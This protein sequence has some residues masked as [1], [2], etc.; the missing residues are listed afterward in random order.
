[1]IG[2]VIRAMG[3]T[4]HSPCFKCILCHTE[5]ANIGFVKHKG[6]MPLCKPCNAELK[7]TGKKFCGKCN[8]P[9]HGEHI[10]YRT[11][12]VHPNHYSCKRCGQVLTAKSREKDGELFCLR[13]HD[14][15]ASI[16]ACCHKPIEGRIIHAI[17]KTWHPEHFVC[18]SCEKAFDGRRHYEKKGLAYC[19]TH[20]TELFGEICF[21]CGKACT[22]DDI[23]TVHG[24]HWCRNHFRCVACDSSLATKAGAQYVD[25]DERPYC[26]RCLDRFPQEYR[27]RLKQ[28]KEV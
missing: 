1:M 10:I 8:L 4:W 24:K 26:K 20:Y 21:S 2:R 25:A 23:V 13:C 28:R 19:E 11:E 12:P 9:I 5:L 6:G 22:S 14:R 3:S 16:C 7:E 18:G 15:A 27:K 17:G